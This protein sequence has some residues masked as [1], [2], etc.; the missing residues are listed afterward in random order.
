MRKESLQKFIGNDYKKC[1]YLFVEIGV[2][3]FFVATLFMFIADSPFAIWSDE[4]WSIKAYKGT[5][6]DIVSTYSHDLYPPMEGVLR[7]NFAYLFTGSLF[8]MKAFSIIPTILTMAFMFLFLKKEFSDKVAIIFLLS[9]CASKPIIHFSTEI[10]MYTW[11]LFF[12]SMLIPTSWYIVK[13]SKIKWWCLFA[14]S[15][16]CAAYTHYYAALNAAIV[17]FY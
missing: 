12:I 14:F 17:Y 10:R 2:I 5:F 11:A 13:T 9:F 3:L 16:V 7:K 4:V 6:V 8:S 15:A 1:V